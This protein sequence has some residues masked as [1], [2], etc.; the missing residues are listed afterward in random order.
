MLAGVVCRFAGAVELTLD[1]G[2]GL[3]TVFGLEL[4]QLGEI[5]ALALQLLIEAVT[6]L[7]QLLFQL[8][9]LLLA[10]LV[11][12]LSQLANLSLKFLDGIFHLAS[13]HG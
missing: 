2:S 10:F 7:I 13:S 9:D 3:F 8:C 5:F 6:H 4:F 1:G 12:A 11:E